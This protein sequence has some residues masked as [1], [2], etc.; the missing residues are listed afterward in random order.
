[1]LKPTLILSAA[2]F[3]IASCAAGPEAK[4][5]RGIAAFKDDPRL[6]EQVDKICFSRNVDRFR[7]ASR[8]TVILERGVSDEYLV[9]IS[10]V[11]SNLRYAQSIGI[12]AS[13]SCVYRNDVL[14]VSDSAFTLDEPGFGPDRCFIDKI[15][16]WDK[17]AEM[18]D[19]MGEDA[20]MDD[21]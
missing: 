17:D 1:M 16:R 7:D 19:N 8:D 11:C 21:G 15:Y 13:Q 12:D 4:E 5:P 6:G 14:I 18:P 9:S 2:C 20:I 3:I 10:G